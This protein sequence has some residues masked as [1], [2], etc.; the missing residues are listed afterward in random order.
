MTVASGPPETIVLGYDNCRCING[1]IF[2]VSTTDNRPD[3]VPGGDLNPVI[4]DGRDPTKYF[5][6]SNFV[7]APAGFY[8]KVGRNTLRIPGVAQTDLSLVKNTSVS[9]DVNVQFRAEFF[10]IFNRAN[11]ADP[12]TRIFSRPGR[13]AGP[14][15]ITR[16]TT[17][18]REI[19][20][21]LKILF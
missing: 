9:E 16:T 2:G 5:D 10:N 13:S 15:R 11:F 18:S 20:L 14:G 4:G 3:L 17:T 19:Q 6:A 7:P 8:G 21:A 1:E 12:G